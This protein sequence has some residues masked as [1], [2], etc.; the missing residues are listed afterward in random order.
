MKFKVGD[1]VLYCRGSEFYTA[2]IRDI[3]YIKSL[4]RDEYLVSFY[5]GARFAKCYKPAIKEYPYTD[6]DKLDSYTI[7]VISKRIN[8][9]LD[10]N[11][12]T[13]E[14]LISIQSWISGLKEGRE[15]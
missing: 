5:N 8:D 10:K 9:R 7:N 12:W 11:G 1:K 2:F 4:N 15:N 13:L 6:E 14:S 3:S